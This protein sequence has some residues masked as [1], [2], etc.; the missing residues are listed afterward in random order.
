MTTIQD[1]IDSRLQDAHAK[2]AYGETI[3]AAAEQ[4][5]AGDDPPAAAPS[6][7]VAHPELAVADEV[8]LT[9]QAADADPEQAT[10]VDTDRLRDM[11]CALSMFID[12]PEHTAEVEKVAG[13]WSKIKPFKKGKPD[14]DGAPKIIEKPAESN[15]VAGLAAG[16][17]A[18]GAAGYLGGVYSTKKS[19]AAP[20]GL[21]A[22]LA[23]SRV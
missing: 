2:L 11:A 4:R 21:G 1:I 5:A 16:A 12:D 23:S 19:E 6:L 7:A 17:A 9:K 22:L 18:G 14:A 8:G 13:L 20:V 3:K 15:F 10:E